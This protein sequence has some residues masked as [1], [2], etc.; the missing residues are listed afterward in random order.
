[1]L[2]RLDFSDPIKLPINIINIKA[3]LKSLRMLLKVDK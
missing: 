2:E 3:R 1:M